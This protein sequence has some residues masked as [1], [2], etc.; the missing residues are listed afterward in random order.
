ML[1]SPL[2]NFSGNTQGN[3]IPDMTVLPCLSQSFPVD[4]EAGVS[5]A[6]HFLILD[7]ALYEIVNYLPKVMED[8]VK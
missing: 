6:P 7:A 4:T 2:G 1:H 3:T 8:L 5:G